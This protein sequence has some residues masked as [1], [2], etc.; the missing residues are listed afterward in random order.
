MSRLSVSSRWVPNRNLERELAASV[1]VRVELETAADRIVRAAKSAAPTNSG[2]YRDTIKTGADGGTVYVYTDD[3]AG[4]L[5][6]WGS[7]NNPPYAPLRRGVRAAGFR[8]ED[9]GVGL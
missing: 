3:I 8:Y 7:V 5:I 6:E 1:G 4:H 2:G 9:K